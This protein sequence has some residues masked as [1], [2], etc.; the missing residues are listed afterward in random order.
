MANKPSVGIIGTINYDR[1]IGNGFLLEDLGGIMY[2]L[3][4]I[5]YLSRGQ[6]QL[7]PAANFG[8]DIKEKLSAYLEGKCNID[9]SG[10]YEL[11]TNNP[12]VELRDIGEKGKDE[13]LKHRVSK[14]TW[15]KI[16]HLLACD[17]ILVN[18]ISGYDVGLGTLMKLRDAYNGIIYM[19]IHSL[20]LG[21]DKDGRRFYRRPD[22][23][24]RYLGIP[25]IIQMNFKEAMTFFYPSQP[26]R[27]PTPSLIE[28]LGTNLMS[29][30]PKMA[31][32]SLGSK[33]AVLFY[34][35]NSTFKSHH[36]I[37]GLKKTRRGEATGCGDLLSAAFMVA[38]LLG[39]KPEESLDYSVAVAT[40]K[41]LRPGLAASSEL[42]P[43]KRNNP[44]QPKNRH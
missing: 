10:L 3:L 7:K 24:K 31:I 20:V 40:E 29:F 37:P 2:N 4:G 11:K 34:S 16:S 38:L 42:S 39:G 30:E 14:L 21:I 32:L 12:C 19:D 44:N 36:A 22:N 23:W 41:F 17:M 43:F 1:I 6:I 27:R 13:N 15:G 35:E 8:Y 9:C 25:D 18:F 28:A 33:G 26:F 5:H